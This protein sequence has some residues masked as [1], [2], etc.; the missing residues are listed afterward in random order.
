MITQPF[1]SPAT[2]TGEQ[3][4]TITDPIGYARR[5]GF[6]KRKVSDLLAK[7]LP[8]LRVGSRRVRILVP[9]ADAWMKSQFGTQRLGKLKQEGAL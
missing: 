8:H 2:G 4:E 5:W 6:S 1:P 3:I 7:G 9:E